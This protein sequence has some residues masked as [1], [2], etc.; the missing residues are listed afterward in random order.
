[1]NYELLGENLTKG[2]VLV[3]MDGLMLGV[4]RTAEGNVP[5]T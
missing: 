2:Y 3:K 1:M 4:S 5:S